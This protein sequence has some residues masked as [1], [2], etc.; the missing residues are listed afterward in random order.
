MQGGFFL[1][2]LPAEA[3][4]GER[5]AAPALRHR[6]EGQVARRRRKRRGGDGRCGFFASKQSESFRALRM[7]GGN[8]CLMKRSWR[9][10]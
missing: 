1:L 2:R 3:R 5:Q 7:T 9:R 8:E 10:R 4:R 6:G